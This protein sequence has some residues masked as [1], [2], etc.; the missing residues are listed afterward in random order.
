MFNRVVAAKLRF[1]NLNVN[2][3][4]IIKLLSIYNNDKIFLVNFIGKGFIVRYR[5]ARPARLLAAP[6]TSTDPRH[7]GQQGA[8]T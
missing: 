8:L 6:R 5:G 7:Y 1:D 2:E 3:P 4:V